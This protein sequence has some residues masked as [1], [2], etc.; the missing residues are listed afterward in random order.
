MGS[1]TGGSFGCGFSC[2]GSLTGAC[3]GFVGGWTG[4]GE[5]VGRGGTSLV[6]LPPKDRSSRFAGARAIV[7]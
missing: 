4:P 7:S 2:G 3:S 1:G 5:L 6:M